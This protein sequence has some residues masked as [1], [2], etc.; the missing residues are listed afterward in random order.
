MTTS[1][2]NRT[3]RG[4]ALIMALLVASL[5]TALATSLIWHE[6]LWLR[7]LETRRDLMQARQLALAG[8]DWSRAVLAE[9]AR[10]SRYDHLGEPWATQVPAMPAEGGEIGGQITDEQSRINLNNLVRNGQASEEDLLIYQRLLS[11]L[12]LPPALAASLTDWLDADD[13]SRPDGAE[14]ADYLA[15]NPAYRAANRELTDIDNLR[16]VRGYTPEIIERLR[17]YVTVLPGYNYLNINTASA[18][19]L[20]ATLHDFPDADIRQ[21]IADRDRIPYLD[22]HDFRKRLP[23]SYLAELPSTE[24]IN[25]RSRYFSVQIHARIGQ[26]DTRIQALLLRSANWPNIVWQKFE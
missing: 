3:Q 1:C 24:R 8:I 26:A 4:A 7:G 15:S 18:L 13:Q 9:D 2:P 5:A 22:V 10:T 12:Q 19:V 23:P 20:T 17:P 14:D 21:I 11:L 16:H 6:N 25:T